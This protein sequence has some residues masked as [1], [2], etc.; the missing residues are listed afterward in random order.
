MVLGK[1][2]VRVRAAGRA[3]RRPPGRHPGRAGLAYVP[4]GSDR[5]AAGAHA[6]RRHDLDPR[7]HL[8][9]R[10]RS[11]R[12]QLSPAWLSHDGADRRPWRLPAQPGACGAAA[13]SRLGPHPAAHPG[14]WRARS[15]TASAQQPFNA[16]LAARGHT[17]AAI[18]EHAGLA[19]TALALA[20]DP[21]L[22]RIDRL[23]GLVPDADGVRGDPAPGQCRARPA[24]R[25]AGRR[26]NGAGHPQL[27]GDDVV[28]G[29]GTLTP[30][31]PHPSP[32]RT[33]GD[34]LQTPRARGGRIGRAGPV[35]RAERRHRAGR[36]DLGRRVGAGRR[37][38]AAAGRGAARHAAGGRRAQ[39]LQRDG[40]GK[41]Q[42]GR[43]RRPG[44]HLRAQP[45]RPRR[46]GRRPGE[47][48][49]GRPLQGRPQPAARRAVLGHAHAVGHQQCR[50]AAPTAA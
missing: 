24:R 31:N 45:A 3:D 8:R 28:D 50:A 21:A 43:R 25:G 1:H 13:R 19:D 41:T 7:R 29:R 4:E 35:A 22:V 23:P 27:P 47:D 14:A 30:H 9:G 40:A 17:R 6:L 38:R 32:D 33:S 2:N 10:A 15:S 11:H 42:P 20:V 37:R 36:R 26:A 16:L 34:E 39:R 18:G 48:E 46:L 5:P 49:G 12:A 44:A